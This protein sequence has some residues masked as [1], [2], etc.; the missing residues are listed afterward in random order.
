LECGSC[1]L[2]HPTPRA[3]RPS[4]PR[5]FALPQVW[6]QCA[7]RS[8]VGDQEGDLVVVSDS[9]D[10]GP[11]GDAYMHADALLFRDAIMGNRSQSAPD[12][13]RRRRGARKGSTATFEP[14]G[15]PRRHVSR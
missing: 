10:V 11:A 12:E 14:C 3:K 9:A 1:H 4:P 15:E 5:R 6:R 8:K 2:A 13:S 7:Y